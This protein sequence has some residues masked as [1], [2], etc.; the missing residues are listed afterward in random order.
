MFILMIRR[1]SS[2]FHIIVNSSQRPHTQQTAHEDVFSDALEATVKRSGAIISEAFFAQAP[3]EGAYATDA[4]PSVPSVPLDGR[5][6][7]ASLRSGAVAGRAGEGEAVLSASVS[8]I[9]AS[10]DTVGKTINEVFPANKITVKCYGC[11]EIIPRFQGYHHIL[12]GE[13][14]MY[15]EKCHQAMGL[16]LR[17]P[18]C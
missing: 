6:G 7:G 15:C 13:K 9:R 18:Q 2:N 17:E 11:G 10:L 12:I 8:Q 5:T 16:P 3:A 4:A 1:S 14:K